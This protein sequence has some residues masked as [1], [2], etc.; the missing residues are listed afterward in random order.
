MSHYKI[1]HINYSSRQNNHIN[2]NNFPFAIFPNL[3]TNNILY[4]TYYLCVCVC[5]TCV[6][7]LLKLRLL[8]ERVY[9][10]VCITQTK[11]IVYWHS[12]CIILV[13]VVA[14]VVYLVDSIIWPCRN[15]RRRGGS[16]ICDQQHPNQHRSELFAVCCCYVVV[17]LSVSSIQHTIAQIHS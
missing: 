2:E 16:Y 6:Y 14:V 17:R 4:I 1:I 3:S 7:M 10:I 12:I 11:Y 13:T 15:L 8:I 9:Q 5:Y